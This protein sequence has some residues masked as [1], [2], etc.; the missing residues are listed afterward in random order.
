MI[1]GILF[2][3]ITPLLKDPAGYKATIDLFYDRFKNE[4]IHTIVAIEARNIAKAKILYDYLDHSEFFR[5]PVHA[6]DRSRMNV[7]FRL[8]DEALDDAFL[9]AC[10]AAEMVQL[11]GHRAVGG[12]RA[13]IYNAMPVDGV[14]RL[15]E[16]MRAFEAEHG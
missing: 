2:R 16:V 15:V 10:K 9:K 8:R 1:P 11:K 13:S 14:E 5:N 6:P 7:V 12:M 4:K 3:D